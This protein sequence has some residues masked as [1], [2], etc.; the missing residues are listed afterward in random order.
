MA[1]GPDYPI[2][3][4]ISGNDFVE[5]SNKNEDAVRFAQLL[6]QQ[7]V[8]LISV[9]GGWHETKMPQLPGEVPKAAFAYLA[10]AI[11]D[12]VSCPVLVSNR[13]NDP[14]EAEDLLAMESADLIGMCRT[15]IADPEWPNKVFAGRDKEIRP[16][17]A[18]NQGCLANTFFGGSVQCLTNGRAG[19]ES[20]V[21]APT[22]AQSQKILV[23]GGG[24]AGCEFALRAAQSGHQ[25][26]LMEKKSK[27][28]GWIEL[29]AAAP[30][31]SDFNRLIP[32]YETMLAK[33]GV[34]LRFGQRVTAEDVKAG[35]YDH[36]VIA[37]G[38]RFRNI[39]FERNDGSVE[40]LLPD[41]VLS[42]AV[43]PGRRVVVLGGGAVGCETAQY[44][45]HDSSLNKEQFTFLFTHRAETVEKLT[46]LLD[47]S[48]RE[49]AVCEV[50]PK[51][52]GGF[53]S[54]CA[55][56]VIK[57]LKRFR[58]PVYTS[59]KVIGVWEGNAHAVRV[60]PDGEEQLCIPCDTM[61]QAVGTEPENDL[62]NELQKEYPGQLHLVGNAAKTGRILDAVR[63]AVD[64]VSFINEKV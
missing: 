46:S 54:G 30:G 14:D 25:V 61:I 31:K 49:I 42:R 35:D 27:L 33:A 50:A 41:E 28:G 34:S 7:R 1:V 29:A 21:P 43:I 47:G 23:V 16:C 20:V 58:V 2:I 10:A 17:V 5:G 57:D 37:T 18:C 6:E 62:Y 24:A 53:D 26:T 19:R 64:L 60:T 40:I 51:A 12:A 44:L 11:K 55:W 38:S 3:F 22:T 39:S 59:T 13:I 15:L 56:P 36:V 48:R 8:N 9:T 32:Y 63:Q 45:A 4:R 52:F